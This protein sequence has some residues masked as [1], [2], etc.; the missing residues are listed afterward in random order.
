MQVTADGDLY[1]SDLSVSQP[2]REGEDGDVV[3]L[4]E[5]LGGGEAHL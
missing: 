4:A 3:F 5:V 1:I 2:V